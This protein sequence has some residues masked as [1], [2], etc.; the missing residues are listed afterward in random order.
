MTPSDH[1]QFLS[2][3]DISGHVTATR[4]HEWKPA[5]TAK[6]DSTN[7]KAAR[8][9]IRSAANYKPVPPR[10]DPAKTV[11]AKVFEAVVNAANGLTLHD[12]RHILHFSGSAISS[13]LRDLL[14]ARRIRIGTEKRR[15]GVR[16]AQVYYKK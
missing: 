2:R 5:V 11:E 13:R 9:R 7:A 10:C 1:E 6:S 8:H 4:K 3:M 16:L 12:L 14:H 15:A